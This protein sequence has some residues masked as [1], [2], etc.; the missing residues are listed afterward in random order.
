LL[1]SPEEIWAPAIT[2]HQSSVSP[3]WTRQNVYIENYDQPQM[4]A[5]GGKLV[6]IGSETENGLSSLLAFDGAS[7]T[8]IWKYGNNSANVVTTSSSVLFVGEVGNVI[9]INPTDGRIIWSTNLPARSVTK[10]LVRGT[11]LHADTVSGN[12]FFLDP[13]TGKSIQS[14]DYTIDDAPNENVPQ[15]SNHRMN[16]DYIGN[17]SL[18]Q[19]QINWPSVKEVEIIATDETS[20]IQ[21]WSSTLPLIGRAAPSPLGVFALQ[22]DGKLLHLNTISGMSSNIVQFDP[23]LT[24]QYQYQDGAYQN[25]GYFV[26][27]D[28][29]SQ[30][31]YVYLG[32]SRQLFAFKLPVSY[33]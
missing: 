33:E 13:V 10:V 29:E 26:T 12:H 1:R 17:I 27:V 15:L 6:L 20:G 23:T 4:I 19:K 32:D 22:T 3:I 28:N 5:V 11:T 24:K 8:T 30:M 18:F 31:L 2:T 14:I 25:Y 21:L 16:L 9:A 7:G